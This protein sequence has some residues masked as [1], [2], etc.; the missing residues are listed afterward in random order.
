MNQTKLRL[1][2][3]RVCIY[4]Y[5]KEQYTYIAW[6]RTFQ[7]ELPSISCIMFPPKTFTL[8]G[9]SSKAPSLQVMLPV[10]WIC[11]KKVQSKQSFFSGNIWIGDPEILHHCHLSSR[12][13]CDFKKRNQLV[14]HPKH[15]LCSICQF[16]QQHS[17][18]L[19]FWLW[20]L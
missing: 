20:G 16:K 8:L 19:Y 6:C 15:S 1:F 5:R 3:K 12:R 18:G 2:Y 9:V 4:I 13:G 17:A 11:K 7:Y 10:T 14:F